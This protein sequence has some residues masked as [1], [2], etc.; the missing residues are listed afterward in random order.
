MPEPP[1]NA[2]RDRDS[3]PAAPSV[4]DFKWALMAV[5]PAAIAKALDAYRDFSEAGPQEVGDPKAFREHHSAC[6]AALSHLESLV[7]LA[8]WAADK[9]Q[10]APSG[11]DGESDQRA[12]SRMMAE[13]RRTLSELTDADPSEAP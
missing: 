11:R 1:D 7:R 4:A 5:L 10:P 12:L 8:K 13:A 2:G 6:K 3:A 9:E